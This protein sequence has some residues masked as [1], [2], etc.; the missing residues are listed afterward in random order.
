MAATTAMGSTRRSSAQPTAD[1]SILRSKITVPSPPEWAVPRPRLDQLIANGVGGPLTALMGPPGTGKTLAMASWAA[2]NQRPVA[3]VTLDEF[4]NRPRVLWSY[5]M[6]ALR[7]AGV[8][9]PHTSWS[10]AHVDTVDHEFLVRLASAL[11]TAEPP[12]ILVLDDLHLLTDRTALQGLTYLMRNAQPGL[13]VMV[14]SRIDPLLPLHRF[15]L[16]GELTEIRADQLAFTVPESALLI[17]QHGVTLPP[18][19]LE[20]LTSRAEGWAAGLR[21]AAISMHEH[22]DPEQFVK[23]L[24]AE[25]S[26]VV[27]Y[28]VEEVLNAQPPEIRDLLLRTSILD[29]FDADIASVLSDGQAGSDLSDL[30]R[31]NAFVLPAGSGWYRYHSLF[32]DVLRLKLRHESPGLVPELHRRAAGWYR[33]NGSLTQ[34]VR[35]AAAAG[36]WPLAAG[37]VV[38]ELAVG[39]LTEARG[40]HP[41][42][43][44]FTQMPSART[45]TRPEPFLVSAALSLAGDNPGSDWLR[46]AEGMIGELPPG[47]AVPARLAAAQIRFA[48]SRRAGDLEALAAAAAETR[49]MLEAVPTAVL[50]RCAWTSAQALAARGTVELWSG[51]LG[52]AAAAFDQAIAAVLAPDNTHER[53]A[54]LG[55]LA[56]TDALRGRLNR[57]ASIA[58]Q[59]SVTPQGDSERI[60]VPISPAAHVAL[61][62]VHVERGELRQAHGELK[63]AE[64]A[65]RLHPD[66]MVGTVACMVAARK[67]LAEGHP[68]GAIEIVRKARRGWPLPYWL[69]RRLAML[70]A[71]AC[72]AAGDATS[73][74]DSA[75]RADAASLEAAVT[76]AHAWLAAGDPRAA[77]KSL[78]G[79]RERAETVPDHV[80]LEAWLVTARISYASGDRA[81]GRRSLQR[82]LRLGEPERLRLPFVLE[83]GWL[84]RV[85][86]AD[87]DLA[88]V[89][90]DLLEPDLVS[91]AREAAP[92]P[93]TRQGEPVMLEPLSSRERE[94]LRHAADMLDTTEIAAVLFISVNTV[95]SHLKS[96]YRKLAVTHRGE[97]VRRAKQLR[98]L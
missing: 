15:R 69:E 63:R 84:R 83:R 97:A 55:Y 95:K 7:R 79:H 93:G 67:A 16:A 13:R 59:A 8:S 75:G 30:V 11:A 47:E 61:A 58:A 26:P 96:I 43:D 23:E 20:C 44:Q 89:Y 57:A 34:A 66:K 31:T 56:L 74:L 18:D 19:S 65:L 49:Q 39:Q 88:H 35:H 28:L 78:A 14:A 60:T 37:L 62:A 32:A 51:H 94:V 68:Q 25:D 6:T 3:W 86:R 4:D 42:A 53:A 29:S 24:V 72:A 98:I 52:E 10:A 76:Q 36:D 77:R 45:W 2:A 9:V 12:V 90:R 64:A 91:P 50:A 92:Q 21:L 80:R 71:R 33:C 38:G 70:E 27:G 48:L 22:P 46:A 87:P 54:C 40:D 5:V 73:A 17:A 85:L 41:L 82:A 81:D 1:R